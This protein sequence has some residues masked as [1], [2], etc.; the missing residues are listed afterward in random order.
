MVIELPISEYDAEVVRSINVI[1]AA[2]E[3]VKITKDNRLK[4][5]DIST[6][7][8]SENYFKILFMFMTILTD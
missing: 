2:G 4:A 7:R 6:K 5:Y 3:K 8:L 1:A